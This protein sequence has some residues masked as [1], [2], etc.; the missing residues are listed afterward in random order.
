MEADWNSTAEEFT[1]VWFD[2]DTAQSILRSNAE[3]TPSDLI[4]QLAEVGV[5]HLPHLDP[6]YP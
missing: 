2:F 5:S 1:T 3:F 4:K 6:R